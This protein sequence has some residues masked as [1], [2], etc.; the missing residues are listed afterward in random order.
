MSDFVAPDAEGGNKLVFE[1]SAG[2]GWADWLAAAQA[3]FGC[4]VTIKRDGNTLTYDA[5]TGDYT[6]KTTA[7]QQPLLQ[8]TTVQQPLQQQA[9]WLQL[10]LLQQL[11]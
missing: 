4:E 11:Q 7:T 8:I 3:G 1:N 6:F 5:K 10:Q 9:M 2:E